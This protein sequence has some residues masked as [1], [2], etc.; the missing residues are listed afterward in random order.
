ML[1]LN[2]AT[3]RWK[4][5][6]FKE[7]QFIR[8]KAWN[9][10]FCRRWEH[11][12][13]VSWNVGLKGAR[14]SVLLLLVYQNCNSFK[15]ALF[16]YQPQI[17][18]TDTDKTNIH[19]LPHVICWEKSSARFWFCLVSLLCITGVLPKWITCFCVSVVEFPATFAHPAWS[20]GT[21]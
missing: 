11:A 6:E 4:V 3:N 12:A 18:R 9:S 17:G 1:S 7:V 5:L 10:C 21:K 16:F 20:C 14:M 13:F 8:L 15:S 2:C 19:L